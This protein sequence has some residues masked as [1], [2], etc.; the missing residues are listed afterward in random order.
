MTTV[1]IGGRDGGGTVVAGTVGNPRSMRV[2]TVP[3]VFGTVTVPLS[4]GTVGSPGSMRVFTVPGRWWSAAR[5]SGRARTVRGP[6]RA[7]GSRIEKPESSMKQE[8]ACR[9]ARGALHCGEVRTAGHGLHLTRSYRI[10]TN[11]QQ[12]VVPVTGGVCGFC[13]LDVP[14]ATIKPARLV[15]R[16]ACVRRTHARRLT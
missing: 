2:F 3:A 5:P 6:A 15:R 9:W 14:P 12:D 7:G 13:S 16:A 8:V 10:C 4:T 11:C 1:P